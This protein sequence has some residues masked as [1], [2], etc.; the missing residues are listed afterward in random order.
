[1]GIVLVC[2]SIQKKFCNSQNGY[3]NK[4]YLNFIYHYSKPL[5]VIKRQDSLEA[6]ITSMKMIVLRDNKIKVIKLVFSKCMIKSTF[7]L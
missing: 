4:V 1:M 2:F 7:F 5:F 6:V 3:K